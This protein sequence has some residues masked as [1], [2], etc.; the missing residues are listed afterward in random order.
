MFYLIGLS[1]CINVML[2]FPEQRSYIKQ[3]SNSTGVGWIDRIHEKPFTFIEN[4]KCLSEASSN[5]YSLLF[6][7]LSIQ[8]NKL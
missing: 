7:A 8:L 6:V 3:G 2:V 1:T 5:L 4:N